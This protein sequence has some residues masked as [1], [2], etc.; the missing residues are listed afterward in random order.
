MSSEFAVSEWLF[1]RFSNTFGVGSF[2]YFIEWETKF[3]LYLPAYALW[4]MSGFVACEKKKDLET[5]A[6]TNEKKIT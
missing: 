2:I 4:F 6:C 3:C 5:M 1:S